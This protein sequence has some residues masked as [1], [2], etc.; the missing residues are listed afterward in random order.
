MQVHD[1]HFEILYVEHCKYTTNLT[2][3]SGKGEIIIPP[4]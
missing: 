2:K 1:L 4:F 3:A